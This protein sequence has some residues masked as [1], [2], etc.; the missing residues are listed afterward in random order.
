M[1]E[2]P[3]L[4]TFCLRSVGS[5]SCSAE[6][7]FAKLKNGEPSTASRLLRSF[8]R[9]PNARTTGVTADTSM[10]DPSQ[11][12]IE[13]IPMERRPCIGPGSARRVNANEVDLN[14]P[15]VGCLATLV[16]L[17]VL[18]HPQTTMLWMR[19]TQKELPPNSSWSTAVRHSMPCSLILI[20]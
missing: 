5:H 1:R 7:S 17:L 12:S 16:V 20:R 13:Q 8:H 11:P 15:I 4:Q 9:R 14:H 19:K 6:D 18:L 2:I 10:I 3:D